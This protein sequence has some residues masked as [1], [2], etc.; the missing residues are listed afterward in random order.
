MIMHLL[1]FCIKLN[2]LCMDLLILLNE[3]VWIMRGCVFFLCKI[4]F[5]MYGFC[6][7]DVACRMLGFVC[8]F[9]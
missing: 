3:I 5:F 8:F 7:H 6:L 9:L 1:V 2:G 4:V